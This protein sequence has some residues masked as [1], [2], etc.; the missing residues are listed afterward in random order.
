L[1]AGV[2]GT[3]LSTIFNVVLSLSERDGVEY[4]DEP[5]EMEFE[6]FVLSDA[7]D[8]DLRWILRDAE[9]E[10]DEV[11]G[12]CRGGVSG[13]CKLSNNSAVVLKAASF[14]SLSFEVASTRSWSGAKLGK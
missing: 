5:E 7:A 10:F 13:P 2:G 1:P 3:I 11:V 9:E 8:E 14:M 6:E 12:E 4:L